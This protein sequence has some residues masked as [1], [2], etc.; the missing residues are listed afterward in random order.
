M[1]R[2]CRTFIPTYAKRALSTRFSYIQKLSLSE[3][4]DYYSCYL[5]DKLACEISGLFSQVKWVRLEAESNIIAAGLVLLLQ[6]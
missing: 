3:E 4:V 2:Y 6:A 1:F 5:Y